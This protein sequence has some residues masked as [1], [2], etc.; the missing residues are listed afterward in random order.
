MANN[1]NDISKNHPSLAVETCCR[2]FI[3]ASPAR[4]WIVWHALRS[5]V[6]KGHSGALEALGVSSKPYVSI[7]N[8]RLVPRH[9]KIGGRL[10]S[11]F[12]FAS[13]GKKDQELLVDYAVHF[14][15]A[16][17]ATRPKVFKLRRIIFR[18]AAR[19][20]LAAAVS[21]ADMTTRRH[22]PDRH[23]IDL[24]INGVPNPLSELDVS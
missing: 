6:K 13:S 8:V 2:W 3:D 17:G 12:D 15:R 18:P 10:R 9:A 4:E 14:T 11:L 5:L 16:N 21:F 23:R 22:D 1:L 19:I 7:T 24:L 20:E